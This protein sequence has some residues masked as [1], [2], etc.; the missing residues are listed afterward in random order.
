MSLEQEVLRIVNL[1][2][3]ECPDS[4][5]YVDGQCSLYGLVKNKLPTHSISL[6]LFDN[7]ELEATWEDLDTY[8]RAWLKVNKE[9]ASWSPNIDEVVVG[10]VYQKAVVTK[11]DRRG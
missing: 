11:K 5:A 6:C 4:G 2:D 8:D 9:K 1:L 10:C 7:G 3:P